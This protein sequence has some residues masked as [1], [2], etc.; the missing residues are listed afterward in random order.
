MKM[1]GG[2]FFCFL[3]TSFG[4]KLEMASPARGV[5]GLKIKKENRRKKECLL[6]RKVCRCGLTI[7]LIDHVF[8]LKPKCGQIQAALNSEALYLRKGKQCSF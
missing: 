3:S 5:K 8:F 7:L 6:G 4:M 1:F 2:D